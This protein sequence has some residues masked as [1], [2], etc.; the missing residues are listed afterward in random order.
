MLSALLTAGICAAW[1]DLRLQRVP[2]RYTLTLL[3]IGVT[4]QVAMAGLG[5]GGWSHVA[6]VLVLGLG[7]ALLMMLAGA[8]SPRGRQDVLGGRGRPAAE[9]LPGGEVGLHGDPS[10]RAHCQHPGG[11]RRGAAGGGG[12]AAAAVDDDQ[13]EPGAMA[14][15]RRRAG[16]VA[17]TGPELRPTR[18]QPPRQLPGSLHLPRRGI[19]AARVGPEAGKA[20]VGGD[21]RTDGSRA[22]GR[23]DRRLE[24]LC[25][26]LGD[27]VAGGAGLSAGA[28]RERPRLRVRASGRSASVWCGPATPDGPGRGTMGRRWSGRAGRASI[29][30]G[31]T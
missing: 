31:W 22:A 19:P 16:W 10:G 24:G 6:G 29:K 1:T 14:A 5:V 28:A 18:A 26:D 23:F 9:P 21:S 20:P 13:G 11:L 27:G 12:L 3:G 7:V 4:G 2:N 30:K 8:W 25:P 17:R 15:G